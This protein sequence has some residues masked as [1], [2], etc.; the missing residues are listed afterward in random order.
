MLIHVAGAPGSGT[1]TLGKALAYESG[2]VFIEADDLLWQQTDP[3]YQIKRPVAERNSLLL[4]QLH[5]ARGAVV[6]GS[7]AGWG[8]DVEDIFD[9]I[10][11]LY[12]ESDVRVARLIERELSLFGKIDPTFIA[13]ARQYDE[14][15]LPGRSLARHNRWLASR[16]CPVLRLE[17][18]L[19]TEER[20]AH[21][22]DFKKANRA[23]ARR[24][25][26]DTP[27][28]LEDRKDDRC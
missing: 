6:A 2:S 16:R 12:V 1:S 27:L 17:G 28:P 26:N 21:I 23:S 13:W 22:H 19:Q 8:N 25:L 18:D 11:F 3:P 10:V 7:I 5:G 15:S 14:G 24:T 20:L 9:L 4:D